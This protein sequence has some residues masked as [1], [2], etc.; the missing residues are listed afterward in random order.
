MCISNAAAYRFVLFV[1]RIYQKYSLSHVLL[2]STY[3]LFIFTCGL[4]FFALEARNFHATR[5]SIQRRQTMNRDR[6]ITRSL[7]PDIFNNSR[8]LVYIH[9]SKTN[10]LKKIVTRKLEDYEKIFRLRYN[11]RPPQNLSLTTSILY[12][13]SCVTTIGYHHIYPMTKGGRILSTFVSIVGFP[14]SLVVI[15]DLSYLLIRLLDLPSLLFEKCWA[16]FRFCTLRISPESELVRSWDSKGNQRSDFRLENSSRLLGIP[17]TLAVLALFGWLS[18]GCVLGWSLFPKESLTTVFHYVITTLTTIGFADHELPDNR[19]LFLLSW[20]AFTLIGLALMSM[21][22]N[23]IHSKFSSA[24][25]LPGR[26]YVPIKQVNRCNRCQNLASIESFNDLC[27]AE[28]PLNHLTTLGILQTDDKC[29]LIDFQRFE[30][31]YVDAVVQ[32]DK[33]DKNGNFEEF[34]ER[35]DEK[36]KEKE[37]LVYLAGGRSRVSR[38]N[39]KEDTIDLKQAMTSFKLIFL[40]ILFFAATSTQ[41]VISCVQNSCS[42]GGS[43]SLSSTQASIKQCDDGENFY[44]NQCL[45]FSANSMSWEQ[46]EE[47]CRQQYRAKLFIT[48]TADDLRF[49][50]NFFSTQSASINNSIAGIWLG[51]RAVQKDGS[52]QW[53]EYPSMYSVMQTFWRQGEPNIYPNYNQVCVALST[54]SPEW[55]S[56]LCSNRNLIVCARDV[57][58]E[59]GTYL[60]QCQCANGFG[61]QTCEIQLDSGNDSSLFPATSTFCASNTR[62][63]VELSCPN[64][65]QIVVDYASYGITTGTT[66]DGRTKKHD[67]ENVH[68]LQTLINKCEGQSA[69]S[70][71]NLA[72]LFPDTPCG[73]DNGGQLELQARWRCTAETQTTC[74]KRSIYFEGRCYEVNFQSKKDKQFDFKGA[75]DYCNQAGGTLL[76]ADSPVDELNK[77]VAGKTK[78]KDSIFWVGLMVDRMGQGIW[79]DGTPASQEFSPSTCGVYEYFPSK[80]LQ[81]STL[82]CNSFASVICIHAPTSSSIRRPT[83]VHNST[84]PLRPTVAPPV[85]LTPSAVFPDVWCAATK[86]RTIEFERTRACQTATVDCPDP[87]NVVGTVT[88]RCDCQ[89][90]K[91]IGQ[92]NSTDC[93]HKWVKTLEAAVAR[94]EPAEVLSNQLNQ[95]LG[96]TINDQ[97]YGGDISGSVGAST[98]LVTLARS[99]FAALTDD[100]EKTTKSTN[101]TTNI[102]GAGDHLFSNPAQLVWAML[103][104]QQK[105][106]L[107]AR[108]MAVLQDSSLLWA[109]Y[110]NEADNKLQYTQWAVNVRVSRPQ[111]LAPSMKTMSINGNADGAT[112]QQSSSTLDDSGAFTMMNRPLPPGLVSGGYSKTKENVSFTGFSASPLISLPSLSTIQDSVSKTNKQRVMFAPMSFSPV[113]GTSATALDDTAS[114]DSNSLKLAY[115]I[116]TALGD[117]LLTNPSEIINSQVIGAAVNDA[118][119]SVALNENVTFNFPHLKTEGVTNARCVFWDIHQ[120]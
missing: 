46:G 110:S 58:P 35:R 60:S 57:E 11:Y 61:G 74:A 120:G 32:T 25:W 51:I 2:L 55:I 31:A 79:L 6:F 14:F 81:L 59:A 68:S 98:N 26:M 65:A 72:A 92:P 8:L 101:F 22:I 30:T 54:N 40:L 84:D 108:L 107:A 45:R 42:N 80:G 62:Q 13:F 112:I 109:D 75:Q 17:A 94:R 73:V 52:P 39:Q 63:P 114:V 47:F 67:C 91:W 118:E 56:S 16:I 33:D 70:I 50:S 116:F 113:M 87:E 24:Y 12:I 115:F 85:R 104:P 27:D 89:S 78:N 10:Y 1:K 18:L 93:T 103:D 100:M 111:T 34:I 43:C 9:E 36:V 29:P 69:C 64:G 105:V 37:T 7:L 71:A 106:S 49:L 77:L 95:E 20:C 82:P 76:D 48:E 19:P 53:A 96:K 41:Q 15:H 99:Q 44:K 90:G 119:K 38:P 66:C 83:Q 86:W 4:A 21:F 5:Q 3:L 102:G 117:L 23:L 88:W 97:L 28:S